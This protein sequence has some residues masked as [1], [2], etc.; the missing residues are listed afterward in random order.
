MKF[1][2]LS[3]KPNNA[4]DFEIHHRECPKI[5]S[6]HDRIYIGP[7][8]NANEALEK[9]KI[10]HPKSVVPKECNTDC[11]VPLFS[12]LHDSETNHQSS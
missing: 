6:F 8:N 12:H 7:F 11:M 3:T 5:P 1:Y 10:T 9:T 2:Y 4:G